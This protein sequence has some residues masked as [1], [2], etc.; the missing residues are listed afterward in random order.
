ML[1]AARTLF[2]SGQCLGTGYSCQVNT[3]QYALSIASMVP[4]YIYFV[5][6]FW[7][8]ARAMQK[9]QSLPRQDFKMANLS[10]R[11]QVRICRQTA[12]LWKC[13]LCV[14]CEVMT[15]R[16]CHMRRARDV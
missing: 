6:Y 16:I 15:G 9:L 11:M 5:A 10:V 2:K 4:A 14:Y 1:S 3:T 7:H 13:A 8:L 12:K